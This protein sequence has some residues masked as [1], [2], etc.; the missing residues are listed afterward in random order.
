MSKSIEG[1]L[2]RIKELLQDSKSFKDIIERTKNRQ[3]SLFPKE[4]EI[5]HH[6]K[7]TGKIIIRTISIH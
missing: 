3:K 6:D 5:K 1:T 7:K 2:T 4:Y